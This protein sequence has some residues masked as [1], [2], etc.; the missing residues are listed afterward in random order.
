MIQFATHIGSVVTGLSDAHHPLG[1]C[2][3]VVRDAQSY[4]YIGQTVNRVWRRIYAHIATPS[5]LG[6]FVWNHWP[7]SAV[8]RVEVCNLLVETG[9][10]LLE[11]ELIRR[12]RPVVNEK[13]NTGR[14]RTEGEELELRYGL[15]GP[16]CQIVLDQGWPVFFDVE[17]E[18]PKPV[19]RG[20]R[21]R[22]LSQDMHTNP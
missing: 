19:L 12:Y 21:R 10:D 15:L 14:P 4:V 17:M 13:F 18:V 20:R 11:R 2:L 16:S 3:Y 6:R 8:W 7:A 22:R 1:N 5:P 9:T